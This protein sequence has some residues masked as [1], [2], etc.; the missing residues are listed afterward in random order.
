MKLKIFS[1]ILFIAFGL[2]FLTMLSLWQIQQVS[3]AQGG[4]TLTKVLNRSSNVVRVGERLS[5]TIILTNNSGFTLTQVNL[6]DT[7]DQ[8][9]SLCRRNPG[10][11]C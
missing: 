9:L 6:I 8:Y 7:Y 11:I 1:R 3:Q 4:I 5:F 2:L 10:R